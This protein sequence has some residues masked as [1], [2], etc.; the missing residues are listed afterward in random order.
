MNKIANLLKIALAIP[1]FWLV[2]FLPAGKGIYWEGLVYCGLVGAY[3]TLVYFA[4]RKGRGKKLVER[5]MRMKEKRGIQKLSI[6]LSGTLFILGLVLSGLDRRFGISDV[7]LL[8]ISLGNAIVVLGFF[9]NFLV[10]K[11]NRNASRVIEVERG[12]KVVSTGPYS[13]VRHPMYLGFLMISFG[14][15]FALGSYLALV[16]FALMPIPLAIRILDEEALLKEKLGGYRAY[17]GKVRFR[18]VLGIW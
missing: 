12:Q 18:L 5:R 8:E 2:L 6:A 4:F 16:P 10:L 9:L 3:G 11:E 17:C 13:I 15:P 1:A 7:S 14:T